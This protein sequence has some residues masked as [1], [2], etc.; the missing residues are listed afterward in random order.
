VISFFSQENSV[1]LNKTTLNILVIYY[2][3]I[4]TENLNGI[5]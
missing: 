5:L 2:F 4:F 3:F 1:L